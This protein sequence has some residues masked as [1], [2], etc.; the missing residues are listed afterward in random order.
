MNVSIVAGGGGFIGA[1]LVNRLLSEDRNIVVLDNFSRGR[2]EYL[3][4]FGLAVGNRLQFL[5]VDLSMIGEAQRGFAFAFN[6]GKVDEV[7]HLAANSDIPAGVSDARIDLR[8]TFMTTF[9][10]LEAMKKYRIAV[11]HFA[12]SSAIYGDLGATP[13]YESIGPLLPISNYGAMKL[14]S[15]AIICAA[16]ESFLDLANIF[17]FPN[18]VGCPATH[19][20]ILDFVNKILSSPNKLEVLGNGTQQKVYLHVSDLV[21]AMIFI[22]NLK[23][24]NGP[25]PV[26]IGPV[27]SGVSVRFIAESVCKILNPNA[28]IHFGVAD[29]GWVGDVPRV[30]YSIERL[31]S[32][33][34]KPKL[35]SSEAVHL[36]IQE[37]WEQQKI[38]V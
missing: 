4:R 26:N 38:S 10:L 33:G 18:V 25:Y 8:D 17:R 16:C 32:A 15:E 1:N 28:E 24:I 2:I 13:L 20:V 9:S 19:G 14:A 31:L 30:N 29:R 35:G 36:A 22:R 37:I 5:D 12:S 27:D 21:D 23:G 6:S 11:M 3:Q 7:W 34:W